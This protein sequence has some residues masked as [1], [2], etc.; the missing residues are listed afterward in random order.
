MRYAARVMRSVIV[1][2]ARK[3]AAQRRG[4]GARHES[5]TLQIA[6]GANAGEREIMRVHDAL[7]ELA[8][9]D[10]RMAQVVEMRY[11]G[12]MNEPEIAQALEVTERTVR[13]D[14]AK[15]RLWLA[16]ALN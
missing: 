2:F 14:W 3:R 1:D 13:R 9:L 11:F 4:G 8:K 5:L 12:G 10:P 6:D 15:A 7:E 16:E